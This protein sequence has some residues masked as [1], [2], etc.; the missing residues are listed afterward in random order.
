MR[1]WLKMVRVRWVSAAPTVA[2]A[3]ITSSNVQLHGFLAGGFLP[4][5]LFAGLQSPY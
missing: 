4:T 5:Q 1:I 3:C 2:V